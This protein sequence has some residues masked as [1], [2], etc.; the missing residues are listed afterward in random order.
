M[1]Q[2]Q[3]WL[4]YTSC[5][6][7]STD[8]G[9]EP[10]E[11]LNASCVLTHLNHLSVMCC[12]GTTLQRVPCCDWSSYRWDALCSHSYGSAAYVHNP[13]P[14]QQSSWVHRTRAP[15]APVKIHCDV[16]YVFSP[17]GLHDMLFGRWVSGCMSVK[18]T[19]RH[20]MFAVITTDKPFYHFVLPGNTANQEKTSTSQRTKWSAGQREE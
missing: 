5:Y 17:P 20:F 6:K 16:N 3:S 1:E 4:W 9:W 2:W 19:I 18:Q 13:Q 14:Q 7:N 12:S 10:L 11:I 8:L 15:W